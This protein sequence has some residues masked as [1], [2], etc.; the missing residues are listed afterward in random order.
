M[1]VVNGVC[2]NN[3]TRGRTRKAYVGIIEDRQH[4]PIHDHEPRKDMNLSPPRHYE[5]RTDE[6]DLA[7]VEG[8]ESHTKT[9][10]GPEKLVDDEVFCRV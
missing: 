1:S 4:K 7:P 9:R 5:R 10:D 2:Q 3:G 8:D 6:A